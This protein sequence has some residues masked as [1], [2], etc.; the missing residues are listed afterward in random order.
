MKRLL[1]VLAAAALLV[2]GATSASGAAPPTPYLTSVQEAYARWVANEDGQRVMYFGGGVNGYPNEW[3]SIGFIGRAECRKVTHHGHTGWRCRGRTEPVKLMPGQFVVDPTLSTAKLEI[4]TDGVTNSVTWQGTGESTPYFHQ[5][6]GT[7]VGAQVMVGAQR[8]ASASVNL[9][10]V[11]S[12]SDRG[13]MLR[14]VTDVNVWLEERRTPVGTF[15][16][17]DGVVHFRAT[18]R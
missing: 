7:D 12:F 18:I 11:A 2:V 5:H 3:P 1:G 9:D 8:S 14:E 17:R 10:G 13:G 16:F 15:T 4:T 6:A